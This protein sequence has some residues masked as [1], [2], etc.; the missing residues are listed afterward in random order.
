MS[1]KDFLALDMTRRYIRTINIPSLRNHKVIFNLFVGK[2][3]LRSV[4]ARKPK[5]D[6][7][8]LWKG[9]MLQSPVIKAGP[10]WFCRSF[11]VHRDAKP[12]Q[13]DKHGSSLQIMPRS[14]NA[15]AYVNAGFLALVDVENGF[16]I[17]Q[18]PTIVFGGIREDF[19]HANGVEEFLIGRSMS[20]HEM[21]EEVRSLTISSKST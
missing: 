12:P 4:Q 11:K 2:I 15:H 8:V 17:T 10:K 7:N 5:V 20:D 14:S 9:S 21:F 18:K 13:N 6:L 3:N 16:T 1:T 19:V